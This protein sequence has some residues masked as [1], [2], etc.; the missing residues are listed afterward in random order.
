MQ[1]MACMRFQTTSASTYDILVAGQ[2][3]LL[4]VHSHTLDFVFHVARQLVNNLCLFVVCLLALL[5][6]LVPLVL[7]V[8]L[9]LLSLI[10]ILALLVQAVA[11]VTLLNLIFALLV[12]LV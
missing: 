2:A 9:A 4:G 1:R 5:V 12:V 11:L 3:G 6:L 10:A 8:L 7:L